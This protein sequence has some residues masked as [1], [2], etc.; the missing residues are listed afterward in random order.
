M[1]I[2]D[3]LSLRETEKQCAVTQKVLT[4]W[5]MSKFTAKKEGTKISE[6]WKMALD[7][8]IANSKEYFKIAEAAEEEKDYVTR[9]FLNWF[10][11]EQLMEEN[12]VEDIYKKAVMLE[13]TGGLYAA[14]DADFTKMAH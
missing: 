2:F 6:V 13:R 1:K 5:D 9:E 7:Q 3:H 4:D 8:E 10:L 14:M 12:A 11:K